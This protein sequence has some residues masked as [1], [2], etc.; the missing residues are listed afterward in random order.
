MS[1]PEGLHLPSSKGEDIRTGF[2]SYEVPTVAGTWKTERLDIL[3]YD[4]GDGSL[5][6]FEIKGPDAGRPE[7]ENLF[8]QGLEHQNWLE[9]NKMAVKFAMEGPRG[10]RINTRK[11]VKLVLG[12]CED[13][14]GGGI[15]ELFYHLRDEAL[16]KDRFLRIEFCRLI[17]PAKGGGEMRV[18]RFE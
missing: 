17:P 9:A 15:P 11:R 18:G 3:G 4:R 6:A 5:V 12:F 8:F 1:S 10:T 2:L 7:L 13:K 16:R 14:K